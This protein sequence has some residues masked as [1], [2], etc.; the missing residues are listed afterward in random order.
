MRQSKRAL[1]FIGSF[2]PK[3]GLK[4]VIIWAMVLHGAISHSSAL[5][6]GNSYYLQRG[7]AA[8]ADGCLRLS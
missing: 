6:L 4:A 5:I 3:T 1:G 7:P 2:A 8:A